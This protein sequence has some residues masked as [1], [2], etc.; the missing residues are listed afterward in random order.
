MKTQDYQAELKATHKSGQN[1]IGKSA[2]SNIL[3]EISATGH[4]I[5][6]ALQPITGYELVDMFGEPTLMVI[7]GGE[8]ILESTIFNIR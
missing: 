5:I 4:K 6:S 8:G 2:Q 3:T 1:Y 7:I